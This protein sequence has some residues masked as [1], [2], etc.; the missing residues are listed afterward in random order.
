MLT[1]LHLGLLEDT[2][3]VDELLETVAH[4]LWAHAIRETGFTPDEDAFA[5]FMASWEDRDEIDLEEMRLSMVDFLLDAAACEVDNEPHNPP[6][7]ACGAEL[8]GDGVCH[9]CEGNE[10]ATERWEEAALGLGMNPDQITQEQVD[11]YHR[12]MEE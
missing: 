1:A 12:T 8:G 5:G 6:C 4:T 10:E 2:K 7:G 9:E 11:A 3:L